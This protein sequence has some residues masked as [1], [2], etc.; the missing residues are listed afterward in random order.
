MDPIT[1]A[2][3]IGG[4]ATLLGGMQQNASAE[5]AS[6]AQIDFQREM[7]NT[8]YQ[9]QVADM[10]AAGLNPM[11]AVMKGGGAS[12]PSGAMPVY[13]NPAA[14]AG[15]SFGRVASGLAS[16]SQ[17]RR[18]D[19]DSDIAETYGMAQA[20]ATLDETLS[21]ISNNA[22]MN[23]K[24]KA[25]TELSLA[26]VLTEKE[27]P[28]QIRALVE[29]TVAMT[30]TEWFKQLNMEKQNE[31]LQAQTKYWWSHAKLEANQVAAEELT[32]NARRIME[33]GGPAASVVKG[34]LDTAFDWFG[35]K[36]KG[37]ISLGRRILGGITR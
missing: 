5:R 36:A 17:A 25:D 35:R 9:R 8:A 26:Q 3:L 10:R 7:S 6:Q 18:T 24:I 32:K 13:V 19:I 33:Q 12:T 15:E 28:A 29:Q 14:Q 1:G 37:G 27:K 16:A 4:A 21:R 20:K 11:L 34:A 2:A 22:A 31:L 23:D 30:K